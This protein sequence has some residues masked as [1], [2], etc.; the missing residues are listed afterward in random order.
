[1]GFGF[2]PIQSGL[3][4]YEAF[5][6]GNFSR[7]VVAEIVP[8]LVKAVRADGGAFGLNVA[9]PHGVEQHTVSGVEMYNPRDETERDA[10]VE[11]VAE[12]GELATA[13]PSVQFYGEGKPGDPVDIIRR[14]M[15]RKSENGAD[16]AVLYT[17][18]NNNHAAEVLAERLGDGVGEH[19]QCLNT[20]VGKMSG[21]VSEPEEIQRRG[22]LPLATG[23]PRAFLVEAFNRILI[24]EVRFSGFAR[25]IQ[26]FEEKTDLL[27]FEEAKLYGH[28]ATHALLGYLL[29]ERGQSFMSDASMD[30]DLVAMA[31]DAFLEESGVP[32]CRKHAGVDDLF[33]QAGYATYVEDLIARMLNPHLMDEV[34]RITRDPKRKL[35]WNDRLVGTM[36]LALSE[37]VR[38]NRF[39]RGAAA[40]LRA[41]EDEVGD[42]AAQLKATWRD[43]N[44]NEGEADEILSLILQTE[45]QGP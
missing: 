9:T 45:E 17:A 33:T 2:G 39:A 27:P 10:L 34:A 42:P 22:Y 18:E 30:P 35:G 29:Q 13:L 7:L 25:G 28:N 4:L 20:V 14:G 15:Q 19:L 38:P 12:A 23:T 31:T 26:V 16:R 44:P 21:V 37:G 3:F 41:L 43:D 40:A 5:R 24:S 8:E 32:L 36:R 1:M 11:A 6:S